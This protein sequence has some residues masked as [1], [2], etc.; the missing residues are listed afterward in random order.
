MGAGVQPGSDRAAAASAVSGKRSVEAPASERD[1]ASQE[2]GGARRRRTS[3]HA[4]APA[5]A[6]RLNASGPCATMF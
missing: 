5:D 6:V 1:V 4:V 2:G 3:S